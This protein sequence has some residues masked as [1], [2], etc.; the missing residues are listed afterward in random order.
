MPTQPQHQYH[1]EA[2]PLPLN[3][4]PTVMAPTVI[5]VSQGHTHD[6]PP[7]CHPT[8]YNGYS[9][10]TYQHHQP[11][12]LSAQYPSH[13]HSPNQSGYFFSSQA[14]PTAQFS[15][16]PPPPYSP[17]IHLPPSLQTTPPTENVPSQ[18][19][20]RLSSSPQGQRQYNGSG[21]SPRGSPG[22]QSNGTSPV[23]SVPQTLPFSW[24]EGSE[25]TVSRLSGTSP[26]PSSG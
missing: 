25:V 1:P 13:T 17:H 10:Y 23:F 15:S 8:G 4:P 22:P 9:N 12:T 21:S 11:S 18:E 20:L 14:T 2:G 3:V 16:P 26:S 24:G 5:R 6:H 19:P 7:I